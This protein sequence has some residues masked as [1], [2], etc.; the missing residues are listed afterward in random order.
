M[1]GGGGVAGGGVSGR[2]CRKG[3]EE[4]EGVGGGREKG[5][6]CGEEGEEGGNEGEGRG[7]GEYKGGGVSSDSSGRELRGSSE[8]G[9]G[10]P[11]HHGDIDQSPAK[12]PPEPSVT[13]EGTVSHPPSVPTSHHQFSH[14]NPKENYYQPL[15]DC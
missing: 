7:S 8:A 3:G 5:W 15:P 13:A 2:E 11:W 10:T 1:D 6:G 12:G 14:Y 4:A 9:T